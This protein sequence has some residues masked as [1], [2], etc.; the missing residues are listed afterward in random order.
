MHK[1]EDKMYIKKEPE[2]FPMTFG[3][4]ISKKIKLSWI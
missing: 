3:G 2:L 4:D 1:K